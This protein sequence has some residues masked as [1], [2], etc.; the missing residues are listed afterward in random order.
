MHHDEVREKNEA[1]TLHTILG[2]RLPL[3]QERRKLH[4]LGLMDPF[5]AAR[6]MT[7]M[8]GRERG[9]DGARDGRKGREDGKGGRKEGREDRDATCSLKCVGQCVNKQVLQHS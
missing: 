1:E 8:E 2:R 9:R 6:K 7:E 4:Y 3:L 5:I